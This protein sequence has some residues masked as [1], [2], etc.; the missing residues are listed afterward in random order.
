[1]NKLIITILS[2]T[3]L[4]GCA[5]VAEKTNFLKDDDVRKASARAVGLQPDEVKLVSRTTEGT[6]TY[7]VIQAKNGK[8]YACT[9]N[10]GNILTAGMMNPP[11][12]TAK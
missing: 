6:N 11:T 8:N 12:C 3:A 7:A 1:L 9:I 5:A 4:G 10:G 2:I